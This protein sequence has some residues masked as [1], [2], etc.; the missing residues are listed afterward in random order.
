MVHFPLHQTI[1][2]LFQPLQQLT[3]NLSFTN[4]NKLSKK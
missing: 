3:D 1:T 2:Y 4:N